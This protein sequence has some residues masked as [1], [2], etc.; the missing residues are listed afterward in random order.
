MKFKEGTYTH[1]QV[2]ALMECIDLI[3]NG[4][5]MR[6][7]YNHGYCHYIE[8][9]HKRTEKR[10]YMFVYPERYVIF[11]NGVKVKESRWNDVQ[12]QFVIYVDSDNKVRYRRAQGGVS[13]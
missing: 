8:M 10:V 12:S 2:D 11:K 9:K 6:T 1:A 3:D 7:E 5:E 4:Y 13:Q